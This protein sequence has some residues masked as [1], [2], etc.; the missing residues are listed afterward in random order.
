MTRAES[1]DSGG[2][3]RLVPF[4]PRTSSDG[5]ERDSD[6]TGDVVDFASPSDAAELM[7]E[8]TFSRLAAL[9]RIADPVPTDVIAAAKESF[10]WRSIDEELAELVYDSAFDGDLLAGVRSGGTAGRQLTFEGPDLVL[11]VEVTDG[12]KRELTCQVVP[13]QPATLEVLHRTGSI[14]LERDEFGMFHVSGVPAGP[15]SLRCVPTEAGREPTK[16]SWVTF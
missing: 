4:P 2:I 1:Y 10:T 6:T 12:P 15:V 9:V 5:S 14:E 3:G 7:R 16:T 11:E 8:A 13:P